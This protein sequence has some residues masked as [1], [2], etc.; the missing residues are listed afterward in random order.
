MVKFVIV[1]V[2]RTGT[3][4]IR[5]TLDSHPQ[6]RCHGASFRYGSR[7]C[8]TEGANYQTGYQKYVRASLRRRIQDRLIPKCTVERYLENLYSGNACQAVGFK[9]LENDF[10]QFPYIMKYLRRHQI[11][12][13]HIV[14]RNVLKTLI[15][16]QVKKV[17]QFGQSRQAVAIT[18]ITLDENKLLK[19]LERIDRANQKWIRETSGLPYL[20][21]SYE[22]YVS[23]KEE[24]LKRM[25]TFLDVEYLPN[26]TSPLTKVNPDDIQQI[27][28]NYEAVERVLAGSRFEWCLTHCSR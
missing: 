15:S 23:D 18:R 4:L 25:L 12:V 19:H 28:I 13:I 5:T 9:L 22:S 7:S 17:R 6:V 26:L 24:E 3:T 1:G 20:Q 27:L 21:I 14:R 10:H 8:P 2:R 16:R 11:R